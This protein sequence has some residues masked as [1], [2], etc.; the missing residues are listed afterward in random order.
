M[1]VVLAGGSGFIGTYLAH[2]FAEQGYRVVILTRTLQRAKNNIRF[3]EWDGNSVST[4]INE[5]ENADILVNLAGKSINCRHTPKNKKE[6]LTSR[7]QATDVLC[8][9]VLQ[10]SR[11]PRLFINASGASY[12]TATCTAPQTE[13][14][15]TSGSDF[16]AQ[17]SIAWE[18]T[19]N[20][21]SF[22][23]TR[24]VIFRIAIVLH[25]S[26]GAL[27]QLINV[28]R[29]G[30]G[31]KI[32]TGKQM[33]SWIHLEDVARA[34]TFLANHPNEN[35]VFNL[36]SPTP[37]DNA[38]FMHTMRKALHAPFGFNTPKWMLTIGALFIGTEPDL[39]LRNMWVIPEHLTKSGFVFKYST[40]EQV[41]ATL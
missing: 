6:I 37:I 12:Y 1:K 4:W 16:T 27:P 36:A 9:A 29:S 34:I 39:L 2:Y 5:L 14:T 15:G 18:N 11:P 41:A 35:G 40:L 19:F 13:S 25:P 7:V 31:G 17:V 8:Q 21:Y 33:M 30:F 22:P 26:G 23:D 10:C 3:V 38:S 20:A 28:V 32:H 24:K